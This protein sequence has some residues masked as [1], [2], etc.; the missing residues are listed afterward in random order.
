MAKS[1][2]R[3]T[4]KA[5]QWQ[6]WIQEWRASGLSVRGFC[7]RHGLAQASFYGWRRKLERRAA[8][9]ATFIPLHILADAGPAPGRAL[10]VILA[11]GRSVR[12]P[13]GFAWPRR[14]CLARAAARRG[15]RLAPR[16]PHNST[17]G[18]L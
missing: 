11:G 13:P 7:L 4:S 18:P 14:S 17:I 1:N 16:L 10:E 9:P 12:V 15:R 2:G 8:Q 3:N 5:E 6:Q